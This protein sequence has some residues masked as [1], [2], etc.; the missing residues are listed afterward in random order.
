M[1]VREEKMVQNAARKI[2]LAEET[3]DA[4]G[5]ILDLVKADIRSTMKK[6]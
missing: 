5:K 1:D 3:E 4:V 6:P 2:E